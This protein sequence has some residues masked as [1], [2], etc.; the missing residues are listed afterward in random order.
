MNISK[1]KRFLVYDTETE[2]LNLNSARPWQCSY[3][4]FNHSKE[5]E[6][7]DRYIWWNDL[8]ISPE[9]ARITKFDYDKYKSKSEDPQKVFDEFYK[10][11]QD[12]DCAIVGQN[13]LNYDTYILMS[14]SEKCG[15]KIDNSYLERVIDTNALSRGMKSNKNVDKENFL[16]WQ[17]KIL[18]EKLKV[19]TSV[20]TMLKEFEIPHDTEKLHDGL[21]DIKMTKE[22]FYKLRH[23]LN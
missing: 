9:A 12:E 7:F 8:K 14:W 18:N 1:F 5:I 16:F 15:R 11:L 2:S 10:L 20:A 3:M 19:K 6:E 13:I 17:Y 22:I 4:L 21:Y 23:T